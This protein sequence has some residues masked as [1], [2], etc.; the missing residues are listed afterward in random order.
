MPMEYNIGFNPETTAARWGNPQTSAFGNAIRG[1]FNPL[2]G[3]NYE[4]FQFDPYAWPT[5]FFGQQM[6]GVTPAEYLHGEYFGYRG[7]M[8]MNL[9]NVS[10]EPKPFKLPYPFSRSA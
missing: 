8:P 4:W 10:P 9:F 1:G 5:N 3:A 7:V 6:V 2:G